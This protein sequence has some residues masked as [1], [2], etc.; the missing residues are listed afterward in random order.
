MPHRSAHVSAGVSVLEAAHENSVERCS[1]YNT[2]LPATRNCI[3]EFPI[4]Y[5]YTHPALNDAG[6]RHRSAHIFSPQEESEF[7]SQTIGFRSARE[8]QGSSSILWG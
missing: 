3:R 6:Q 8:S 4:R 1:G 2:K 5:G 7:L